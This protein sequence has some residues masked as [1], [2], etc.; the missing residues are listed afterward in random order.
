MGKCS[1]TEYY[2]KYKEECH[3]C[4]SSVQDEAMND[5]SSDVDD[6][7]EATAD[8]EVS[9]CS[10]LRKDDTVS[11][12]SPVKNSPTLDEMNADEHTWTDQCELVCQMCKGEE[13]VFKNQDK[14]MNH[15]QSDH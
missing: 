13:I 4:K 11:S 3:M 15:L 9:D 10:P 6:G 2:N 14:F 12:S 8:E 5:V 1:L 7:N